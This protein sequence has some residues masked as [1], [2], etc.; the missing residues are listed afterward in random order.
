MSKPC[1][2]CDPER[3]DV[4]PRVFYESDEWFGVLDVSPMATG[5][6]LVARRS[7]DGDCPRGL[8][9][10]HLAGHDKALGDVLSTLRRY[11]EGRPS[12]KDYLFASL[13]QTTEHMHTHIVPLW[14]QQENDWRTESRIQSGKGFQFL[15]WLERGRKN[16]SH[17]ERG[18]LYEFAA[19]LRSI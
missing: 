5:H 7:R 4:K 12:P 10:E 13:R 8:A 11:Y 17:S 1:W 14:A 18:D 16:L 3:P 9:V 6:A 2:L 15:G 19:A